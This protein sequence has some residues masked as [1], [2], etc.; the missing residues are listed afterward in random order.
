M[1]FFDSQSS[2]ETQG[3]ETGQQTTDFGQSFALSNLKLGDGA[4]TV[5]ITASDY[6][7]IRGALDFADRTVNFNSEAVLNALMFAGEAGAASNAVTLSALQT[8]VAS[9]EA[10]MSLVREAGV[11]AL[12]FGAGAFQTAI[13]S[14]DNASGLAISA[15]VNSAREQASGVERANIAA[16]DY[17]AGA[18]QAAVNAIESANTRSDLAYQAAIASGQGAYSESLKFVE[19]QNKSEGALLADKLVWGVLA[20]IGVMSLQA[21][22]K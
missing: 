15:V 20:L 22:A 13:E 9:S 2:A 11:D 3:S 8:G 7:A 10:A 16:L 5:A 6:G 18:F 19:D 21:I 4:D 14:V 1:G 17:G 12:E